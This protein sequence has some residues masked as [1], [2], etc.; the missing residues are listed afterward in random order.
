M[1]I[2]MNIQ[3]RKGINNWQKYICSHAECNI[4]LARRWDKTN[5]EPGPELQSTSP[6]LVRATGVHERSW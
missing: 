6:A 2:I 5:A 1:N 4:Q 3:Q